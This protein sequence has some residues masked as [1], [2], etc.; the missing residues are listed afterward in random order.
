DRIAPTIIRDVGLIGYKMAADLQSAG[1]KG[2][3]TNTTFDMWWH[4]GFRSAPYYHNSIGIL[5]EAASAN[6]MTPVTIPRDQLQRTRPARG[7]NS[8]LE[9]T[10]SQPDPWQGG[11]W[12]PR[13]IARIEMIAS[14]ALLEMAS[15]FRSQYLRNF[16]ELGAANIKRDPAVPQAF[17]ITA[18][19]PYA[20][21]IARFI[22]VLREQGIE[23]HEMTRELWIMHE[24]DNREYHEIPLGSFLVF[25]DQPQRNNI[26]SLFER[27]T[28]PNRVNES[29]V[30]DPPYDVA[31]WTLPLQMGIETVEV[32]DIQ[33]LDKLR[34][35]IKPIANIDQARAV[36]N[37]PAVGE[38]FAMLRNPL[39][40]PARVGLYHGSMGSMDEGW[41][42]L[43]LDNHQIKY[44]KISDQSLREGK[45]PVDVLILPSIGEAGITNGLSAERYPDEFAG[46][47]G[48][49]GVANLKR[50]V[51]EG[52][53]LVC[54]DASCGLVIKEFGLPIKNVLAG[55]P[56][57]QFYNPGSIVKL[58][59]E[60]G[61]RFA[62]GMPPDTPAYFINSSAFEV[63][64]DA[65]VTVIARYAGK[66]ALMSGWMLGEPMINGKAAMVEASHGKG[67]IVL[68]AFR[69][70][71][72]GQTYATFPLVFNTLEK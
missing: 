3:A 51:E 35:T 11:E 9:R 23:V 22:D 5:S 60:T 67:Q 45:P 26:L 6:L 49:T 40:S 50:F 70:Q 47:I 55:V 17:I 18:G 71:H 53:R 48:E 7:L 37:L 72:R 42:R 30:P 61:H 68:F 1:V 31:G 63:T 28:Y 33:D 41:T 46:G 8:P 69:P 38:P 56:R 19:Q 13:D 43:V 10:I 21:K 25:A 54:F 16:Y 36:M 64:A 20:E 57:S 4:G 62:R 66:D 2:V 12:G 65:P 58:D 27:Q 59:V 29:G 15:K 39:R 44:E 14:R 24:R 52:G 34:S 32:W